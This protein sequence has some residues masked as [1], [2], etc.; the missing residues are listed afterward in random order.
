MKKISEKNRLIKSAKTRINFYRYFARNGLLNASTNSFERHGGFLSPSSS[1][2]SRH[3]EPVS[4]PM[5]PRGGWPKNDLWR[6]SGV[7]EDRGV[8]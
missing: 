3:H 6:D 5:I 8:P 4:F 2:D 7:E 1:M